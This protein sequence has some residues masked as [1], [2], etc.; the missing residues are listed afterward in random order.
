MT[1][2]VGGK[3]GKEVCSLNSFFQYFEFFRQRSMRLDKVKSRCF[4]KE[5]IEEFEQMNK[6]IS[7]IEI[8]S[9]ILGSL[10]AGTPL[11]D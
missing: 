4:L 7:S 10:K 3:K 2:G 5:L 9:F 8:L 1:R 6:A 11:M